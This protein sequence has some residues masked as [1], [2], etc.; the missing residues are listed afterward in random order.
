VLSAWAGE[1][2]VPLW[3]SFR[4]ERRSSADHSES[5]AE[6]RRRSSRGLFQPGVQ[7]SAISAFFINPVIDLRSAFFHDR[8]ERMFA[9]G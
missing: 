5:R 2:G 6:T 4:W 3:R 8:V 1:G 7:S 9:I